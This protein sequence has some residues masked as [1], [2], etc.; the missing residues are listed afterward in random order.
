MNKCAST[1]QAATAIYLIHF[2][3]LVHLIAMN[4]CAS[5][6]GV[7]KNLL[8]GATFDTFNTFD[9]FHTFHWDHIISY[10][11][12]HI[13]HF[14]Y[15]ICTFAAMNICARCYQEPLLMYLI[16]DT[17]HIFIYFISYICQGCHGCYQEA[18]PRRHLIPHRS[19]IN[20][21][22]CI[23]EASTQ[24]NCSQTRNSNMKV[25]IF[26]HLRLKSCS[27]SCM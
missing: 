9:W 7:T 22:H 23:M 17:C 10:I 12:Y 4:I 20:T 21:A 26:I 11:L 2:I 27:V 1:L 25:F 6:R 15:I 14:I 19:H 3:H 18:P 5:V 16:F 13:I 24:E 8:H